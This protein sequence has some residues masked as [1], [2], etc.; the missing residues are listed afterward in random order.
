LSGERL[1]A[2]DGDIDV[3]W[4]YFD[5]VTRATGHLG[6]DDGGAGAGEGIVDGLAG[7]AVVLDRAAHALDGLLS[8]VAGLVPVITVDLP[9]GS[10]RPVS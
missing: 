5:C 9:D 7:A 8:T 3:C 6:G 4:G 2:E 1:P 10:L